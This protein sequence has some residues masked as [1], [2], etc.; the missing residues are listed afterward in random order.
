MSTRQAKGVL[1]YQK[2]GNDEFSTLIRDY[3]EREAVAESRL[4]YLISVAD[5][6][7]GNVKADRPIAHEYTLCTAQD[8]RELQQ[9]A[10]DYAEE[11][12]ERAEEIAAYSAKLA[13]YELAVESYK[14]SKDLAKKQGN[15]FKARY[16]DAPEPLD[17]ADPMASIQLIGL[18][19]QDHTVRHVAKI[20]N[21]LELG[22]NYVVTS[23]TSKLADWL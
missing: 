11:L 10:A 9:L 5:I 15:K 20:D 21:A 3:E 7:D 14:Y 18:V 23:K 13:A 12:I 19:E 8:M 2:T 6:S 17:L 22:R 4:K 1:L 16:P